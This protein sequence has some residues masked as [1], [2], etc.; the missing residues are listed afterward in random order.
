MKI[1]SDSPSNSTPTKNRTTPTTTTPKDTLSIADLIIKLEE[2]HQSVHRVFLMKSGSAK[3]N[4]KRFREKLR[5]RFYGSWK[6]YTPGKTD[7]CRPSKIVVG[8]VSFWNG[9]YYWRHVRFPGCACVEILARMQS[10]KMKTKISGSL[11]LVVVTGG[12]WVGEASQCVYLMNNSG[13]GVYFTMSRYV[14]Y[15]V[16]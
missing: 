16:D 12:T 13:G 2:L 9:S 5:V 7:T 3:N 4:E 10:W 1:S 6:M 11:I 15:I 8:R 14:L